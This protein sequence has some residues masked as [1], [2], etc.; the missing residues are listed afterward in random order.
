[1]GDPH[2]TNLYMLGKG[3]LSFDRWDDDGLP[4]GLVD[5]GNA[6]DFSMNL[7]IT[8]K[9][10]ESSR[11]PAIGTDLT[12]VLKT[13]L[14]GK[15]TLEEFGE[16]NLALAMFGTVSGH[17]VTLKSVSAL[18]GHLQFIG[19]PAHGPKWNVQLWKVTLKPSGDLAMIGEDW[20]KMAFEFTVEDDTENNPSSPFG[21]MT[22]F[23][24]S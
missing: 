11:D 23:F 8:E 15:F 18:R 24:D 20:G 4:T 10:H 1:M 16:D 13:K 7:E 5:I 21:T 2:S 19:N 17:V 14:K 12:V 9:E 6:P 22:E 3:V